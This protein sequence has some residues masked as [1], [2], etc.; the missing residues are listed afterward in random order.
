M[1]RAGRSMT[2]AGSAQTRGQTG[3]SAQELL[4]RARRDRVAAP[5]PVIVAREVE[6]LARL[7]PHQQLCSAPRRSPVR[8]HPFGLAPDEGLGRR[9][10]RR[11]V[12]GAVPPQAVEEA[13]AGQ[14]VGFAH[15]QHRKLRL[16]ARPVA[17]ADR[18]EIAAE[19][20]HPAGVIRIPKCASTSA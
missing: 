3:V 14:A 6:A 15:D 1:A 13:L 11:A 5:V 17:L 12:V 4:D 19:R 8:E 2:Q 10:G 7:P 16:A 20:E 18:A 9:A